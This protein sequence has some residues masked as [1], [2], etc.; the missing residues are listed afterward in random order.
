MKKIIRIS[1]VVCL[2]LAIG[3]VVMPTGAGAWDG[4][5]SLSGGPGIE[6]TTPFYTWSSTSYGGIAVTITTHGN[7]LA[8]TS[9]NKAGAQYEHINSGALSEGY[10]L[11]YTNPYTGVYVNAY[12]IGYAELG[13]GPA[14]T[15]T[16]PVTVTRKTSDGLLELKQ[17]YSF[18]SSG[19][20]LTIYMYIKNLT[21]DQHITGIVLRRQVDYDVDTGG[22]QGWAAYLNTHAKTS[23]DGAFAWNDPSRAPAGREAHGMMLWNYNSSSGITAQAKVSGGILD[24]SCTCTT[25]V[26]TPVT[27]PID[28]GETIQFT[29]P[30]LTHGST[31]YGAIRHIR[32]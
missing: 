14:T 15:T 17:T 3:L 32:F 7:L 18:S 27:V 6:S 23:K 2:L 12:D 30:S 25:A 1:E 13:F 21:A 28:Y 11:C 29:F 19:K 22:T 4:E 9:P 10:V 31:K 5:Q 24:T 16:S 20:Y 26:A 8:F